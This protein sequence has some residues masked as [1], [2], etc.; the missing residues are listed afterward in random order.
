MN[1]IKEFIEK[2][3]EIATDT[4]KEDYLKE[5][6]QINTY[7]PFIKKVSYAVTLIENTMTDKDTGNVK[8]KSEATYLFFCRSIIELYTNLKIEDNAFYEEYD[9]LNESGVL[10]KIIQMIPEKELN[11]LKMLV[12]M[13]KS[14]FIQNNY[15]LHSFINSQVERF[16]KLTNVIFKPVFD[17]MLEKLDNK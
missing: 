17:A 15:E 1:T 3:N 7:V 5:N 4:L 10:E 16:S 12:D 13:K 6:L 11:E 14:D 8:V 2:Y 9:L